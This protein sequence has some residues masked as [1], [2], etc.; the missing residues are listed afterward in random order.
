MKELV[1]TNRV[2][3]LFV[4]CFFACVYLGCLGIP[5][6]RGQYDFS[7]ST[8]R[9]TYVFGDRVGFS[10]TVTNSSSREGTLAFSSGCQADYSLNDG[11]VG[12][13]ACTQAFSSVE[14]PA[15]GQFDWNFELT[16][17]DVGTHKLVGYVFPNRTIGN[18]TF[19]DPIY[20]DVL[21]PDPVVDDVFIDFETYPDGS[22]TRNEY[23]T[24]GIWKDAYAPWG[25]HFTT[26]SYGS[27]FNSGGF[28]LT[29]NF[30]SGNTILH[31]NLSRR[32]LR[33]EFDMP[34]FE[35]SAE[36]GSAQDRFIT[37]TIFDAAG[38][39]I[40]TINSEVV[41]NYPDLQE[42][43]T[44]TAQVP[45]AAVEWASSDP[46]ASVTIDNLYLDV[47]TTVPEPAGVALLVCGV[48]FC[49]D[50]RKRPGRRAGPH[51]IGSYH[52]GAGKR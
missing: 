13:S 34:V 8:S 30:S 3:S 20:F 32:N 41:D 36:V 11:P 50:Q 35:V 27:P 37:M 52:C 21:A 10:V 51:W 17:I 29:D 5:A 45:I 18:E 46:L 23:G 40:N 15:E 31:T 33:A 7:V 9:S 4:P 16:G 44:L 28:N 48:L 49:L 2:R 47:G 19:T 26:T 12:Q 24:R 25:V 38:N 43:L 39:I 1:S 42:V 6:A 22:S 14:V